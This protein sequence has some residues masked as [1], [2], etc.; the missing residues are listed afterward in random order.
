MYK[1]EMTALILSAFQQKRSKQEDDSYA[2]CQTPAEGTAPCTM[3]PSP[4]SES[5]EVIKTLKNI[6]V[7]RFL[8]SDF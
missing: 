8:W 7:F 4:D 6:K 1:I 5:F 2:E 3:L